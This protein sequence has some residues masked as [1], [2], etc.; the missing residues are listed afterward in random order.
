MTIES[1]TMDD[2]R[3][4]GLG[5]CSRQPA[6]QS[7]PTVQYSWDHRL[8]THGDASNH[9]SPARQV[10]SQTATSGVGQPT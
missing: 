4:T 7:P 1:R 2:D 6:D 8:L 9:L 10:L 5:H 3:R